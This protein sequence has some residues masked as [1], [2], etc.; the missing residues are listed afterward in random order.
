LLRLRQSPGTLSDERSGLWQEDVEKTIAAVER[1]LRGMHE[2]RR[3][4]EGIG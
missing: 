4:E 3:A 2:E 1:V